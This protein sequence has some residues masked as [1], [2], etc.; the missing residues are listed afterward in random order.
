MAAWYTNDAMITAFYHPAFAAP[1]G[2]HIMP[3]QKFALVAEGTVNLP[4]GD[5]VITVISDE[6]AG[7]WVDGEEVIVAWSPH[8][9]K[10]DHAA[11]RGGRKKFK[12]EYYEVGGFAELRFDIQRR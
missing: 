4:S 1:I 8:E 2:D 11:I 5:Y 9:S 12:V 3:M 6:G 7:V 10:V